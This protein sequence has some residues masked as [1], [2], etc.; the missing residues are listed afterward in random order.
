MT[1]SCIHGRF[2]ERH[3]DE[4]ETDARQI[5]E[6][7]KTI[8][9]LRDQLAQKNN[10][11]RQLKADLA[12]AEYSY[13]NGLPVERRAGRAEE[14]EACANIAMSAKDDGEY[15]VAKRIADEIRARGTTKGK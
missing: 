5:N 4:C 11:I 2:T 12:E 8:G 13:A 14:R 9:N 6:Y 7:R 3:C 15:T 1:L 10:E